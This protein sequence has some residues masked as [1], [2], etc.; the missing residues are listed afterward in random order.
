MT[1]AASVRCAVCCCI[2]VMTHCY[3]YCYDV[4]LVC[5]QI[6]H[7][8]RQRLPPPV[9]RVATMVDMVSAQTTTVLKHGDLCA[10]Y[11]YDHC[12]LSKTLL[13]R[14]QHCEDITQ[15]L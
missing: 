13:P 9:N 7:Q 11:D 1:L 14:L 8:Y 3:Y 5:K 6:G 2:C 10:L 4:L 15:R 12:T